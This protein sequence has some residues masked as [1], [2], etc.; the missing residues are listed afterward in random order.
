VAQR[1]PSEPLVEEMDGKIRQVGKSGGDA[2]MLIGRA[3]DVQMISVYG[4]SRLVGY[5]EK[6][7]LKPDILKSIDVEDDKVFTMH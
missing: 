7:Q 2:R 4:Y 6:F 3:R 5:D 1:L